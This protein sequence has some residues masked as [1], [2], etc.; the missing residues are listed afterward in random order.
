[1]KSKCINPK[2][3]EMIGRY[4][5]NLLSPEEKETFEIHV[6]QCDACFQGVY[7]NAP[8]MQIINENLEEF[9]KAVKIEDSKSKQAW[10]SII[11]ALS[12]NRVVN[13]FPKPVRVAV[14]V[15]AMAVVVFLIITIFYPSDFYIGNKHISDASD[16]LK[17]ISPN[18]P[19]I[20]DYKASSENI[21]S[22]YSIKLFDLDEQGN[23]QIHMEFSEDK[24]DIKLT[25]N[26]TP[27][28]ETYHVYLIENGKSIRMTPTEAIRDTSF[29]LPVNKIETNTQY[30]LEITNEVGII[31]LLRQR[32]EIRNKN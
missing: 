7:E 4:E 24:K 10:Q 32:F 8:A 26:K 1:M 6:T 27:N 30:L 5:F 13:I 2:I 31:K 14:P 19:E 16:S 29:T 25:W 23:S 9:H 20:M 17:M 18:S 3:G 15:F 22:T 12:N 21:N 28:I 11:S